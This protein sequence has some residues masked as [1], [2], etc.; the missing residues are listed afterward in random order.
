M[1][2]ISISLL[3]ILILFSIFT[4]IKYRKIFNYITLSGAVGGL[5]ANVY[6]YGGD[7]FVVSVLGLVVGLSMFFPLFIFKL[8][9]AGDVKLMGAVGAILGYKM[10][11]QTAICTII[12]GGILSLLALLFHGRLLNATKKALWAFYTLIS[13]NFA[14]EL[15]KVETCVKIPFAIAIAIGSIIAI[16]FNFLECLFAKN[17]IK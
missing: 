5:L 6:V 16:N 8:L 4:D 15:P 13:P 7:G 10:V 14:F 2:V 3:Y 1:P 9:G 17:L 12:V 11:F